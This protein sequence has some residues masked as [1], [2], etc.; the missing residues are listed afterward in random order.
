[1]TRSSERAVQRRASR[2]IGDKTFLFPDAMAA[3]RPAL[4]NI[5]GGIRFIR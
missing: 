5:I 1:M 2:G 3:V 4:N